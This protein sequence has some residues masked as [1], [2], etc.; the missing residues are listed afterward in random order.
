MNP[1]QDAKVFNK[2]GKIEAQ[3]EQALEYIRDSRETDA[4]QDERLGKLEGKMKLVW[5]VG[6][7]A[8]GVVTAL[9]TEKIKSLIG[10]N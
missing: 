10:I 5:G 8:V 9:A 1:E 4:A 2:L 6:V 7:V 3:M